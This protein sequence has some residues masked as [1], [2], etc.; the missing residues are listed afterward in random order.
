MPFSFGE[1]DQFTSGTHVQASCIVGEGDLP[2]ELSWTFHGR[3]EASMMGITTTKLG[4]RS[5]ILQIDAVAAA[6]SG[7]YTC[8]AKNAVGSQNFTAHLKVQGTPRL[9]IATQY[10]PVTCPSSPASGL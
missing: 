4:P 7:E 9:S 1:D 10:L 2:V 8:T 3:K 6:H 5:S